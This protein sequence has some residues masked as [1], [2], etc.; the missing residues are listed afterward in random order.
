M[1]NIYS[2]IKNENKNR[3]YP[4]GN[5][6]MLSNV[7][8][9]KIKNQQREN[10]YPSIVCENKKEYI[11]YQLPRIGAQKNKNIYKKIDVEKFFYYN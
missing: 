1:G 5:N 4:I 6:G 10:Q 9:E 8:W 7:L 2:R 3:I 11:P